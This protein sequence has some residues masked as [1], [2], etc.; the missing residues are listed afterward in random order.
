MKKII[1]TLALTSISFSSFAAN[2]DTVDLVLQGIVPELLEISIS[3]LPAASNL[4]LTQPANS[5]PVATL[6]EKSNHHIGYHIRSKSMKGGKLVNNNDV[7]SFV[8]YRITYN[9]TQIP[10]GTDFAQIPG[11]SN[12]QRGTFT[13]DIRINYDQ[14]GNL[15]A[16]TYS[17]TVT[18]QIVAN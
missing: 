17:D 9:G 16:G 4:D 12:N 2:M 7:N 13:R 10:L 6:T 1:A 14:P 15:S 5:V 18:F 3:T 8:N 11:S